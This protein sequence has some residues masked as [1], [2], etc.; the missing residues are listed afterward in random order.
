ML[1]GIERARAMPSRWRRL[2]HSTRAA[3]PAAQRARTLAGLIHSDRQ[4]NQQESPNQSIVAPVS[5][6]TCPHFTASAFVKA[7]KFSGVSPTN[8]DP[9]SFRIFWN[10]GCFM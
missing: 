1:I 2:G 6:A 3:D 8:S 9:V 10:S 5:F 4:P 7:V